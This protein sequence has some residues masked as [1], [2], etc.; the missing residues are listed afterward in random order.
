M[1]TLD[2]T[3]GVLYQ[4]VVISAAL[5]G[6]GCLQ[7]WYYFR[8]YQSDLC[9]V[10][11]L[12]AFVIVFDT[13]QQALTTGL[14][15]VI[16]IFFKDLIAVPVQLFYIHR[17]H[18]RNDI[19]PLPSFGSNFQSSV[20]DGNWIISGF[21]TLLSLGSCAAYLGRSYPDL[22]LV[23]YETTQF[24]SAIYRG[25]RPN[26]NIN[27]RYIVHM[28]Y[29]NR[30]QLS[31]IAE[32]AS[33]ETLSFA[34]NIAAAVTNVLISMFLV[35]YFY[36]LKRGDARMDEI[37]N[38]LI[39]F[40]FNTGV[41]ASLCSIS[42][43]IAMTVAPHTFIYMFWTIIQS[44]F[45]TNS[46]LVTLNTRDYIRSVIAPSTD[47]E[48]E[49][50]ESV[51]Y[52]STI[53]YSTY[54]PDES[55]APSG[56]VDAPS[57]VNGEEEFGQSKYKQ[58]GKTQSR[59]RVPT[60]V[61]D[62][63]PP[64]DNGGLVQAIDGGDTVVVHDASSTTR[65]SMALSASVELL[66]ILRLGQLTYIETYFSAGWTTSSIALQVMIQIDPPTRSSFS[67]S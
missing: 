4:T 27:L 44:R 55:N 26:L 42:A 9:W 58:S 47:P 48:T 31:T 56:R 50:K 43:C 34:C 30:L 10:K 29:T 46:L 32:L 19:S 35:Y 62:A 51:R 52:P 16:Q 40:A 54:R 33:L 63:L 61:S 41:P 25:V 14:T 7:A 59:P 11:F 36:I 60:E 23:G 57:V 20:S 28:Q 67:V 21:L 38:R 5:Y 64:G 39:V 22:I 13:C 49:L 6:A 8:K 37:I 45:Y 24:N 17:V 65:T 3:F 66:N 12:V 1:A 53:L 18:R 15:L 2:N